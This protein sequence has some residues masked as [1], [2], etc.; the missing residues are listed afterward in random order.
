MKP[1][2][3][4]TAR[5][6]RSAK[7]TLSLPVHVRTILDSSLGSRQQPFRIGVD[8][9]AEV[10]AVGVEGCHLPRHGSNDAGMAVAQRRYV[11]VGVEIA[12]AVS[13][14]EPHALASDEVE[15]ACVE[16]HG[17]RTERPP[18]A[19]DEIGHVTIEAGCRSHVEGIE[20]ENFA[21]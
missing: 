15:R 12:R 16:Q 5:A 13:T 18:A 14:D 4:V 6:M 1:V 19:G 9:L 2:P 7:S 8:D 11:V 3:P 10:A 21:S 20:F 17:C